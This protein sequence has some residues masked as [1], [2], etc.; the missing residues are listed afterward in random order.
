MTIKELWAKSANE[1]GTLTLEQF[2]TLAKENKTK[3]IDVNDT[4][5][6]GYVSLNKYNDDL[7]AKDT[8]IQG[9]NETIKTRD[10][11]L[12]KLQTQ[13]GE[14][15]TDAEKLKTLSTDLESL[16]S[17]YET[18]TKALQ[19]QL[20]KQNYEFAVRE[21]AGTKQFTSNAAKR[22]FVNSMIERELKMSKDGKSI[23]GADDFV[24]EYTKDN[25]DAFVVE[26]EPEPEPDNTVVN[27]GPLPQFVAPTQGSEQ[28]Q[29]ATG[30]F[31]NAFHF[32]T[33]RPVPEN[34]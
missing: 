20:S 9:L 7:K 10:G 2:E 32:T 27:Q 14:A 33:V 13:L 3:F 19:A 31:A 29:D 6:G 25:A 34:K 4:T 17:K 11:D 15:G 26:T 22:D 1:D 28:V 21:F 12:Q 8:E 30:G 18:D 5:H 23:I 16:Q 24:T